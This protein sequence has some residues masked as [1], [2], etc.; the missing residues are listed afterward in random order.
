MAIIPA[1]VVT[2][3]L[4]LAGLKIRSKDV[5]DLPDIHA[6]QRIEDKAL[7]VLIFT[8]DKINVDY[9]SA[10]EVST[11]LSDVFEVSVDESAIRMALTR[12][13]DK[14]H[15]KDFGRTR[16]FSVMK[17]GREHLSRVTR[18]SV[19][20]VDPQKP[21]QAI[22]RISDLLGTF[23]GTVKICDPYLD[24]KTLEVTAM[25]PDNCDV[26]FLSNPPKDGQTFLRHLKAYKVEH[27][28]LQ[29]RTISPGHIHDR[30]ILVGQDMWLVGHS[31]NAIGS[32]QALVV[33]L[34]Q[35]IRGEIEKWFDGTW[36][37]A[38]I[39]A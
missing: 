4:D 9:L 21:H 35:N 22:Q 28:N 33:K 20:I 38:G 19:I 26:R 3:E 27:P 12:A 13:R 1:K 10:A 30:Y 36:V 25:I 18:D 8:K 37:S 23:S 15:S 5:A 24:K 17:P 29:V 6:L 11:I 31:L 14:V 2:N 32:K 34:G 39:V 7:W 16:K